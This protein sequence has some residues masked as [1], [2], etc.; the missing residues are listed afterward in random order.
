VD[1]AQRKNEHVLLM[2]MSFYVPDGYTREKFRRKALDYNLHGS[3]IELWGD[4]EN[5]VRAL[6]EHNRV[7][8]GIATGSSHVTF[9][10]QNS[11]IPKTREYFDDIVHLTQ[12]GCQQFVENI[13]DPIVK[14]T[15]RR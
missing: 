15:N 6:S 2:T 13:A 12:K 10:D 7:I 1:L 3:P 8:E 11:R 14:L 4:A 5:V 9:V